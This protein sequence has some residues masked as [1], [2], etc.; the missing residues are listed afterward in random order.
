M[1]A[2][3]QWWER[4]YGPRKVIRSLVQAIELDAR[5]VLLSA[6]CDL[7]FRHEMRACVI[8]NW[9][10]DEGLRGLT[11][12]EYDCAKDGKEGLSF[13]E[14]LLEKVFP[15]ESEQKKDTESVIAFFKRKNLLALKVIWIK[16]IVNAQDRDAALKFATKF[17]QQ[18]KEGFLIV[19]LA[20]EYIPNNFRSFPVIRVETDETDMESFSQTCLREKNEEVSM[21][22]FL[23]RYLTLLASALCGTDAE[24][25]HLFI[26]RF[27]YSSDDPIF[28]LD[29]IYKSGELPSSREKEKGSGQ[30]QHVFYLLKNNKTED[31][32][33]L[34]WKAQIQALFPV[35]EDI[36][37]VLIERYFSFWESA[38]KEVIVKESLP[39][40]R[41]VH[42]RIY[43]PWALELGQMKFCLN[44]VANSSAVSAK[45]NASIQMLPPFRHKLAHLETMTPDDVTSLEKIAVQY[46][47]E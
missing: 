24:L 31:V 32:R 37:S 17:A 12:P 40:E 34:V 5:A 21:P 22:Y 10:T 6:P 25:S 9:R 18:S 23:C 30:A 7:A 33:R 13:E 8:H 44:K 43:D 15:K 47:S 41:G 38:L 46:Y 2:A 26:N 19:E 45:D 36:R 42:K 27:H 39:D 1:D 20:P 11:V 29:Q 4:T 3:G 35:L 14:S 28:V 16:G